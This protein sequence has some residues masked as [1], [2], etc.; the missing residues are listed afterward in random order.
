VGGAVPATLAL[1]LGAP[2]SFGGFT[3]GI[4]KTYSA[5]TT[6]TVISTAGDAALFVVD[7]S[8]TAPG[9]LVNGA[10][11]LATPLQAKANTGTPAAVSGTPLNLLTY[12]GPVSNDVAAI[13]FEQSIGA[14]EALRTGAYSKTL[15]Y[16]LSSTTP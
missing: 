2:I 8:A 9:R 5:G 10:F 11:S 6:A 16:T 3:P 1:T 7:P 4:A 12:G 13:T 15:T 14:N